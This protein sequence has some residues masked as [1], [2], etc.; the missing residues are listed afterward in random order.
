MSFQWHQVALTG[1]D[2]PVEPGPLTWKEITVKVSVFILQFQAL[3][4]PPRWVFGETARWAKEFEPWKHWQ[5]SFLLLFLLGIPILY[6]SWPYP[7]CSQAPKSRSYNND[8]VRGLVSLPLPRHMALHQYPLHRAK[9][10]TE[11]EILFIKAMCLIEMEST[12]KINLK[13]RR[14]RN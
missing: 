2:K 12:V 13:A 5:L 4:F 10:S 14:C 1:S 7:F 8:A 11:V 3:S 9:L 6:R